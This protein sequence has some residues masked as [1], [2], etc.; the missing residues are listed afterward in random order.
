[1]E[2]AATL[3]LTTTEVAIYVRQY[4]ERCLDGRL[5]SRDVAAT[6]IDKTAHQTSFTFPLLQPTNDRQ[7]QLV[8]EYLN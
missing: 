4:A 1:M 6:F 3:Q 2:V 8:Y 7:P 5:T